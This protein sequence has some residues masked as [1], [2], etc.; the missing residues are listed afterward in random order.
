MPRKCGHRGRSPWFNSLVSTFTPQR[1]RNRQQ[2]IPDA[3]SHNGNAQAYDLDPLT[4]VA[5]DNKESA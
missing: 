1:I 4:P 5:L 2:L 3:A